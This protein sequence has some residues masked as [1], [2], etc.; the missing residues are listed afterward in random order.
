[1]SAM[2]ARITATDQRAPT[3]MP[4]IRPS[5]TLCFMSVTSSRALHPQAA[6]TTG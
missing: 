5:R 6:A 2:I 1:M 3:G 4:A